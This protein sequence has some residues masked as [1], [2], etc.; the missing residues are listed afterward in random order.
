MGMPNSAQVAATP[1]SKM[2]V[3]QSENS[4]STAEIGCTLAA[5]RIDAALTSDKLMPPS[6]PAL[7]Y[8]A[9]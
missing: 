6:F 4:T 9:R 2:S 7:T 8:S 3:D 5:L 1:F